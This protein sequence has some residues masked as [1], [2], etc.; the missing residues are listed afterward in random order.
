M[1]VKVKITSP[2]LKSVVANFRSPA[3]QAGLAKVV[4][5]KIKEFVATGTSPVLGYGRFKP[6]LDKSRY[7]GDKKAA[8]PVNL[9]LSGE[10]LGALTY[11]LTSQTTTIGIF[12]GKALKKAQTHNEGAQTT[13]KATN[14][15][16]PAQRRSA[17]RQESG[18]SGVAQRKF[19][20]NQ[21][22]DEFNV[23]IMREIRAYYQR[24]LNRS[25]LGRAGRALGL[26]D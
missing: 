17:Q 7:P 3:V 22:G 11:R 10:M 23:T 16:T 1:A 2:G 26:I 14:T 19:I 8:R 5:Q 13:S 24:T 4:I 25:L 18:A 20:P 6:Y 9:Y 21:A 12:S 15:G